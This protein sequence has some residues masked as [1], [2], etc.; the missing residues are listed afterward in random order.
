MTDAGEA[1]VSTQ[2]ET[3]PD[4]ISPVISSAPKLDC[5]Y[6]DKK[7]K[8]KVTLRNHT[9]SKHFVNDDM[10]IMKRA[11]T[12]F[13][14]SPANKP[15]KQVVQIPEPDIDIEDEVMEEDK[16]D[17]D[18]AEMVPSQEPVNKDQSCVTTHKVHKS[19]NKT[20]T[21]GE[22]EKALESGKEESVCAGCI[23]GLG[24]EEKLK[25]ETKEKLKSN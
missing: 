7:F 8:T 19:L 18:L 20:W 13:N 16:E 21:A 23:M 3:N 15:V 2:V 9:R 14:K 5:E 11:R 1:S 10:P 22:M 24:M 17:Q 25:N 6:C 12:L 4:S